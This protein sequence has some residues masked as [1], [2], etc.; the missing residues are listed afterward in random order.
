[1][2]DF[3]KDWIVNPMLNLLKRTITYPGFE[4][5]AFGVAVSIPNHLHHLGRL[6]N[7][8]D[9]CIIPLIEYKHFTDNGAHFHKSV[10]V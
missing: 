8:F 5:G 2:V 9:A 4:P 1:M 7:K 3:L 10:Q 6:D